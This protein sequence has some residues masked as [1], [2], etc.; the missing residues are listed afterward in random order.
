MSTTYDNDEQCNGGGEETSNTNVYTSCEQNNVDTITEDID[1]MGVSDMSTCAACGKEE[2]SD[3]M[4]NCNKCKEVKYCNAACKKKHR[5]KHKKACDRRVAEEKL[6]K[7]VEPDECPICMLPRPIETNTSTF[8]SC[9]GKLICNGCIYAMKISEGKDLCPF[10][11][12]PPAKTNEERIDRIKKLMDNGNPNAFD[13]LG[14]FYLTGQFDL[15]QD[16]QKANELY[17]KAGKLGYADGYYNLGNAF[18]QGRGVEEDMKK[19]KYYWELA[20]M[21]G[22]L[23][24][25]YNLGALEGMAGDESRAMKYNISAAKA[26]DKGALD[27]V[28]V[29]FSRGDVTK[30]EYADT[31][32]AYQ[33]RQEEMKSDARDKAAIRKKVMEMRRVERLV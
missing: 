32:R 26:G 27:E 4:N 29:R 28:K 10:C 9:C 6:F 8:Q 1:S 15:P 17:L 16:H 11:R 25:R 23:H 5:S 3:N 13:H 22:H 7:D 20:A 31:L 33:T 2:N 21:D 30:D 24:A 14:S 18:C 12:R 19:A